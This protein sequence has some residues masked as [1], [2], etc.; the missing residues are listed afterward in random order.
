MKRNSV[1]RMA[2]AVA[3]LGILLP[4]SAFATTPVEPTNDVALRSG[5]LLVGQ[6]VDSQGVAK[7]G[8]MVS[9]RQG[10]QEVVRTTTD[11][12]GVFA[13]QGL[14]GGHYQL[15][16][17]EGG[18]DCRLWAADTAPPA[19]R[20]AALIVSGNDVVRGQYGPAQGWVH[21]MK[22]HPYI[23]AGVVAAAIAIPVAFIDDDDDNGS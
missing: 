19:A 1:G 16:T 14:R 23:T 6:V 21:W 15:L 7:S 12:N 22:A 2:A 3:S 4:P 11:E 10:Q 18:S 5:G 20:P 9:I 13:A 8:T 17:Q